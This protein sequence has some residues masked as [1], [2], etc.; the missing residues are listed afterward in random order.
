MLA[1]SPDVV[2][3]VTVAG[4]EIVTLSDSSP[5]KVTAAA[6]LDVA[7]TVAADPL[8][9]VPKARGAVA[10]AVIGVTIV[11]EE[12]MLADWAEAERLVTTRAT[13]SER[14]DRVERFMSGPG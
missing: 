13:R 5:L 10:V 3:I 8:E 12:V 1:P 7:A 4:I 9:I 14:I 11:A 2:A 6:E